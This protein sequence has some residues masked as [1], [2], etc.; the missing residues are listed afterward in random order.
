MLRPGLL[1]QAISADLGGQKAASGGGGG[2][3][4]GGGREGLT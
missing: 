4:G 1:S 2:G 3:G